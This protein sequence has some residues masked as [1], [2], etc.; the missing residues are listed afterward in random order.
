MTLLDQLIFPANCQ[1]LPRSSGRK[2]SSSHQFETGEQEHVLDVSGFRYLI[3][4]VALV[5][6]AN[7][8]N[9]L[10]RSQFI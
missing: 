7:S 10:G 2:L 1:F 5:W 8:L 3:A 6:K 9:N 4:V